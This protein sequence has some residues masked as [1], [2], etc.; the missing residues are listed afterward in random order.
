MLEK[1]G[2]SPDGPNQQDAE[3]VAIEALGFL[4]GDA[5]LLSRFLALS[6]LEANDLRAAASDPAFF[7]GLLDFFLAHEGTLNAFA[8]ASAI[9]PERVAAARRALGGRYEDVP[10]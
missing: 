7:A 8:A 9:A 4:A 3:S 5:A 10:H 2:K 1:R 6:G